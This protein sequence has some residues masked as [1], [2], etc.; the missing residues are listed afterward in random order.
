MGQREVGLSARVAYGAGGISTAVKDAAVVHFLSFYFTQVAGLPAHFFGIAAFL[1]QAVDAIAD[2][3]I[4]TW[5]DNHRSRWGRRHPFMLAATVPY[6]IA[7]VLLFS[8]PAGLADWE[9]F[10]WAA[11]FSVAARVLLSV[12]AIPHSAL[13]AEL[14]T[15]YEERTRIVS[16]RTLLAWMGAIALPAGAY[17][18][19]F[20]GTAGSDG[21]LLAENYSTYAWLSAALILVSC[22]ASSFGTRGEIPHLPAP[23]AARRISLLDPFRDVIEA[24]RN[25]NFRRLFGALI[26]I[27]AS[28]GVS[29]ILGTYTWTY[30]WRFTTSESSL[31]TASSVVPTIA[32]FLL[33]KPLGARFEKKPLFFGTLLVFVAN[34]LWWYG[35]RLLNVLPGN[36]SPALIALGLVHQFFVVAAVVLNSTVWASMVADVADEHEVETGQRKDGVFFAALAFGLKVPTGLGQAAGAFLLGWIGLEQGMQPGGVSEDV[37]LRLGL[38]AGPLVAISLLAPLALMAR[39][40]LS[41]ARHAELRRKLEERPARR[42]AS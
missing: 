25:A 12:F 18:F 15:D 16:Y 10:A 5:S 35:G 19:V 11:G 2:P 38:A 3:V 22:V 37:L 17:L 31:L 36:E 9:L 32:A 14:S 1:G 27:G 41:R 24:L 33:V 4:G 42:P 30:F 39:F 20:R 6:A 8:P 34:S 29:T 7:F 40:D 21:R 26:L 23:G 13:G 28:V